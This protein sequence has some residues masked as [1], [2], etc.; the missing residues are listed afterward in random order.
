MGNQGQRK[1]RQE[2]AVS[3]R[4][5]SCMND[6]GSTN[7]TQ[8]VLP[9]LIY[10]QTHL[11]GDL[12]LEAVARRAMA[13]PFHFHRLF[14]T[15]VGE[16]LKKY[17][18]RLR[19]ERAAF[20][21][22]IREAPILDVALSA[23]YRSH[24]TFSRA[25]RRHFG[26]TPRSYR[27]AVGRLLQADLHDVQMGQRMTL[28]RLTN[29]YQ[30]S[31]VRVQKLAALPVAFIRSLGPYET[32]DTTIFDELLAWV[33]RRGVFTGDNLLL[34]IG[35]DDPSITPAEKLR[36]DACIQLPGPLAADDKVGFQESPAGWFATVTYVGPY[37]PVMA[38]AYGAIFQQVLQLRNYRL[39]GLPAVE[40]YRTTRI[41]A[42]ADL[43][44]TDIYL[45]VEKIGAT[46]S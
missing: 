29:E 42:D 37:G 39:V 43:N 46:V 24:E 33:K 38:E 40:I 30:I 26:L 7:I 28:N 1:K 6:A 19:L 21:L 5:N 25:F 32:V 3:I 31:A 45:P 4:Y 10:I 20:E 44:E 36:F 13:S 17:T 15:A 27:Q 9:T 35:H 12:S 23:G 11:D 34:G 8:T 14:Q 41:A 16:T 2:T 18:Q 22:K